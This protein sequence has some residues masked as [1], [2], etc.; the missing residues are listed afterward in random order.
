MASQAVMEILNERERK[1][2]RVGIMERLWL[3]RVRKEGLESGRDKSR[4]KK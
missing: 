3:W 1:G 4:I 2:K